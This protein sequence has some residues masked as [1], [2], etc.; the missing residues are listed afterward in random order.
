MHEKTKLV[1]EYDLNCSAKMLYSRLSTPYGL[2]E[3][4]ADDVKIE[5]GKIFVFKWDS[6][7]E[8]A[9]VI[10]KKELKYIK[11][12]WEEDE[13]DDTYFEFNLNIDELTGDIALLVTDFVEE[14]DKED[15]INLWNKQIAQLKHILGL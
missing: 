3:W 4:F 1:L 10:A 6:S 12:K 2:A 13:D 8:R 14:S 5:D 7:Q 15:A 9:K 11:F